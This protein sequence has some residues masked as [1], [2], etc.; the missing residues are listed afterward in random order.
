MDYQ[1][2]YYPPQTSYETPADRRL[3]HSGLGIASFLISIASGM[4]E[5]VAVL[6]AG[7]LAAQGVVDE[8]SVAI[9]LVGFGILAGL[10]LAMVDGA[11]GIV[12]LFLPDRNK[13]FA[14]LGLLFNAI[15][16]M[17]VVG[18]ILIGICVG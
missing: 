14:V 9:M 1:D 12:A 4:V 6:A 17:G 16:F 10:G 15:V 11:L 18:L 3:K 13:V 2:P 8:T 5:F 7:V